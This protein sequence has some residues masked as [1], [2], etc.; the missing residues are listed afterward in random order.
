[1]NSSASQ[2]QPEACRKYG[3]L[4]VCVCVCVLPRFTQS[5][6]TWKTIVGLNHTCWNRKK[7]QALLKY[8]ET[9]LS[10]LNLYRFSK[11]LMYKFYNTYY[12]SKIYP[13]VL[14]L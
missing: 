1:M 12:I 8:G 10:I 3:L 9:V 6:D 4:C 7:P 5:Q 2:S 11:N 14:I 13:K